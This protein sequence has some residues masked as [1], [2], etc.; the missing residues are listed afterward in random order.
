MEENFL[1]SVY[2]GNP[3]L[4]KTANRDKEIVY[5]SRYAK[6]SL[7]G[8]LKNDVYILPVTFDRKRESLAGARSG[9][10]RLMSIP[11]KKYVE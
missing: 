3:F 10:F 7:D 2:K 6:D 5:I 11:F 4:D 8:P 1:P 9:G